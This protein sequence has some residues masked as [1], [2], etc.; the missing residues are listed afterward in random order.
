MQQEQ[1]TAE[2]TG[3]FPS[4]MGHREPLKEDQVHQNCLRSRIPYVAHRISSVS[5]ARLGAQNQISENTTPGR[6]DLKTA[7]I[8]PAC[9]INV[10]NFLKL[11]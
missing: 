7:Q 11:I 8:L 5:T 10:D 1:V 2:K 3:V 4:F 6:L 9:I